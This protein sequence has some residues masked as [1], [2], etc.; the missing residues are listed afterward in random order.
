MGLD[1]L[2]RIANSE[3]ENYQQLYQVLQ[4]QICKNLYN[5]LQELQQAQKKLNNQFSN[6]NK[7]IE[8]L[9]EK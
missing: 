6:L 4:D 1:Y 7:N 3:A 2:H 5:L 8:S 9:I